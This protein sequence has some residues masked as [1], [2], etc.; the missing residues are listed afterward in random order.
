MKQ[1]Y[2]VTDG[3]YNARPLMA[4]QDRND[5]VKSACAIRGCNAADANEY[6][7]SVPFMFDQPQNVDVT[8]I[9]TVIDMTLKAVGTVFAINREIGD[10]SNE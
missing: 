2:I 6:I 3:G 1:I 10:G 5:A 4:F 8:D 7:K 9:Q